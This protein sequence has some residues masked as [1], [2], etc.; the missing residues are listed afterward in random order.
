MAKRILLFIVF[1]VVLSSSTAFSYDTMHLTTLP[2]TRDGTYGYYVGFTGGYLNTNSPAYEYLCNDFIPRTYVPGDY[3]VNV[4]SFD[5]LTNVKFRDVSKNPLL[6]EYKQAAWLLY[7]MKANP[8]AT[9][10]IQFA[11]WNIFTPSAPDYEGQVDWI[12][13]AQNPLNLAGLTFNNVRVYTPISLSDGSFPS[14][15]QEFMGVVPI[16]AS[17]WLIGTGLVGLIGIRR[18]FTS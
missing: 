3:S 15:Q 14:N 4:S 16:P 8:G 6:T 9:A 12:S 10:A 2:A 1:A 17:I 18:R 13:A 11:I 5:T 7:Q